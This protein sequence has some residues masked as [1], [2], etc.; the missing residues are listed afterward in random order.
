[1][2][3]IAGHGGTSPSSAFRGAGPQS[4]THLR[5]GGKAQGQ[6]LA[7][8]PQPKPPEAAATILFL[9]FL[10]PEADLFGLEGLDLRW[11]EGSAVHGLLP[12]LRVTGSFLINI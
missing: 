2:H 12:P 4:E 10:K 1:M 6:S 7:A 5:R 3:R 9:K 11:G 8:Q